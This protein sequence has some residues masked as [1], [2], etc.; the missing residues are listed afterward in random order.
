VL[1]VPVIVITAVVGTTIFA[2]LDRSPEPQWKILA[3][4]VSLLG[5][6]LSALQT[7]FGFA[8]TAERHKAV[9]T[10]YRAVRRR[11]ELFELKYSN[12]TD[13]GRDEALAELEQLNVDL[14]ALASDSPGL[15]ERIYQQA[16]REAAPDGASKSS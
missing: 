5:A 10:R 14:T 4:L 2:T 6:V 7:S 13:E 9:G 11:L 15:P 8:Q 1:G 16:E 12:R 3:G